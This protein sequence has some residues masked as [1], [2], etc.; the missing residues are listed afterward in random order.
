MNP[1]T[2]GGAT[3]MSSASAARRR[4]VARA[5]HMNPIAA[6]ADG[7]NDT[8]VNLTFTANASAPIAATHSA[9]YFHAGPGPASPNRTSRYISSTTVGVATPSAAR[10]T[11]WIIPTGRNVTNTT[12]ATR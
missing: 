6:A 3:T 7:T 2:A 12:A 5:S 11:A 10:T 9:T 1:I 8:A 4:L